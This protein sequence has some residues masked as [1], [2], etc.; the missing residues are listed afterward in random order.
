[1]KSAAKWIFPIFLGIIII[2]LFFFEFYNNPLFQNNSIRFIL[3]FALLFPYRKEK[4]IRS[5]YFLNITIMLVWLASH[6]QEILI[7]LMLAFVIAYI[8]NPL[9]NYFEQKINI[10]RTISILLVMTL[11]AAAAVLIVIYIIPLIFQQLENL[12]NNIPDYIESA[13]EFFAKIE[14]FLAKHNI[15]LDKTD[16]EYLEDIQNVSGKIIQTILNFLKNLSGMISQLINLLIFPFALYY[17]SKDFNRIKK[18]IKSLIPLKYKEPAVK[19]VRDIDV[20]IGK[21]IRGQLLVCLVLGILSYI[22]LILIGFD[23]SI[24]LALMVTFLSLIPYV[25]VFVTVIT[26]VILGWVSTSFIMAVKVFIALEIVQFLEGNFI[27]PKIMGKSVG[28]H[29]LVVMIALI[30]F[31]KL[32]GFWGMLIAVPITAILKYFVQMLLDNYKNSSLY[33]EKGENNS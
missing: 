4:Y 2:L 1:M 12:Y 30:F 18:G 6:A 19:I 7:P 15:S 14:T 27:T 24:V 25:G 29:P 5:L 10:N 20:I 3:I 21:F 17:F 16:A 13:E 9:I 33:N 28:L 26:G 31:G 23:Y 8:L 32:L 11:V 22:G